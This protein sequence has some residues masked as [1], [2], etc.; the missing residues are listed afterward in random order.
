MVER[1]K[2]VEE[3]DFEEEEEEGEKKEEEEEE[4]EEKEERRK[5]RH[6]LENK[7]DLESIWSPKSPPTERRP[8]SIIRSSANKTFVPNIV[9]CYEWQ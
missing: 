1:R 2:R 6:N 7:R 5:G 4:G 8:H 3:A 9:R